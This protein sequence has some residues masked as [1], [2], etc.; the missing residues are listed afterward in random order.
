MKFLL[1]FGGYVDYRFGILTSPAHKSVPLGIKRGMVWAADNEVFTRPFDPNRFFPWLKTM[2]PY[3]KTC[4]FVVAP[5]VVGNARET[6]G[7]FYKWR[8]HLED[9]P[10]AFVAQDG[11][12]NIEFP[13]GL[14]FTDWAALKKDVYEG[15]EDELAD[16]EYWDILNDWRR[17]E[18]IPFTT[19]FIG[20]STNWKESMTVAKLIQKAQQMGKHVHI[21][22]VNWKRRYNLFKVLPGSEEF[23][24]D[25]TRNRY[26]GIKRTVHAWGAYQS[27]GVLVWMK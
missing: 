22:R 8:H 27:Q 12:E 21:G 15:D 11:Q 10:V 2:E 23:T 3:R 7:L 14:D 19:L 16:W 25:G 20:G 5:D 18:A 26:E 4:L 9:W 6:I 24:C 13:T 1:P 17:E